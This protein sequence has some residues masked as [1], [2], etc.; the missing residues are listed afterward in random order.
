VTDFDCWLSRDC[1]SLET[2]NLIHRDNLLLDLVYTAYK[3]YRWVELPEDGGWAAVGR[4]WTDQQY[5]NSDGVDTLDFFSN[6]EITVPSGD[7]TLRYNILW[8]A[9]V[10]DPPVMETLL[11][12]TVRAG[13]QDGYENTE[14]YIADN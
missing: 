4:S 8:G 6:F 5:I 10:F 14:A 1:D 7:G 11:V 9:V 13:M 3:D 12:N 2:T